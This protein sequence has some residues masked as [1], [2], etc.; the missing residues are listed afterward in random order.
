MAFGNETI[1]E[2]FVTEIGFRDLPGSVATLNKMQGR[3]KSM[4]ATTAAASRNMMM[5]G[6][7]LAAPLIGVA[8]TAIKTSEAFN[9][10][11]ARTNASIGEMAQFRKQAL[12]VGSQLPLDTE[13]I[14]RAQTLAVQNGLTIIEAMAA[15]PITAKFAVA[16]EGMGIEQATDYLTVAKNAFGLAAD[17]LGKVAD[18]MLYAE[19]KMPVTAQQLGEGFQYSAYT[20]R[21]MGVELEEYISIL[22][23][24]GKS[25]RGPEQASQGFQLLLQN[26]AKMRVEGSRGG[27]IVK[28]TFE[29]IGISVNEVEATLDRFG[30]TGLFELMNRR[31]AAG[32]MSKEEFTAIT[33]QLG[34][35]S[36]G[37]GLMAAIE[38][39]PILRDVQAGLLGAVGTELDRQVEEQMSGL[40]GAWKQVLANIDTIKQHMASVGVGDLLEKTFGG[41]NE[42]VSKLTKTKQAVDDVT[43]EMTDLWRFHFEAVRDGEK[44]MLTADATNYEA[45]LALV[46]DKSGL[47]EPDLE[48]KDQTQV[49]EGENLVKAAVDAGLFGVALIGVGAVLRVVS[50]SLGGF[51]LVIGGVSKALA[52]AS[53][54]AIGTR[55]ALASLAVW[56][57]I[58]AGAAKIMAAATWLFNTALLANPIVWVIAGIAALAAGAYY[59]WRNWESISEKWSLMWQSIKSASESAINAVID[60]YNWLTRQLNKVPAMLGLDFE[61]GEVPEF[62]FGDQNVKLDVG[63][64]DTPEI[65]APEAGEIVPKW[66]R[67]TTPEEKQSMFDQSAA[68]WEA[69]KA[70]FG[71]AMAWMKDRAI[72]EWTWIKNAASSFSSS[73]GAQWTYIAGMFGAAWDWMGA[74]AVAIIDTVTGAFSRVGDMFRSIGGVLGFDVEEPDAPGGAGEVAVKP[75]GS[76]ADT[77]RAKHEDLTGPEIADSAM[78]DLTGTNAERAIAGAGDVP[79]L[80]TDDSTP[81][82]TP[83]SVIADAV[84]QPSPATG[85]DLLSGLAVQPNVNVLQQAAEASQAG[86]L[87]HLAAPL[88]AAPPTTVLRVPEHGMATGQPPQVNAP[89]TVENIEINVAGGDPDEVAEAVQRGIEEHSR[90]EWRAIVEQMDSALT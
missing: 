86:G 43:G 7:A 13:D 29:A 41:F 17:D 48:Y 56:S 62:K 25:G 67:A 10:L 80:P 42:F 18:M 32:K 55:I 36:Y 60:G 69:M 65:A 40:A 83:E 61:I 44:E 71:D 11:R 72:A 88:P 38:D 21:Q 26:L 28:K 15:T 87:A 66:A 14:V 64:G 2:R 77:L 4:Q 27:A 6:A 57:A 75:V 46:L 68:E 22:G 76:L 19:T 73:V 50:W 78:P 31:L 23:S 52:F 47:A 12:D 8:S 45:A 81:V 79:M 53:R 90:R 39:A 1:L 3:L 89:F 37:A 51:A 16:A 70:G 85:A 63:V 30:L 82:G 58:T 24:F 49:I 74:K 35:S 59:L 34:G 20:A 9:T 54:A 33:S 5:T 84:A